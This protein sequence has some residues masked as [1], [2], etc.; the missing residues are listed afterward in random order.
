MVLCK[1]FMRVT[2]GNM[3]ITTNQTVNRFIIEFEN[4]FGSYLGQPPWINGLAGRKPLIYTS[5]FGNKRRRA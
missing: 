2:N 4:N 1:R 3:A 5:H